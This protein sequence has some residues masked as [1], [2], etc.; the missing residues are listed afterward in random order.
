MVRSTKLAEFPLGWSSARLAFEPVHEA[1]HVYKSVRRNEYHMIYEM[2]TPTSGRSFGLARAD[3]LDGPW[4]RVTDD[5]AKPNQMIVA[6]DVAPWTDLISHGEL[7]RSGYD[8]RLEYDPSEGTW[9]IQ[10]LRF[11]GPLHVGN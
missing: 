4:S 11:E 5:Y 7:I 2:R 9:L 3:H 6:S 8:Q 10:G 1:S